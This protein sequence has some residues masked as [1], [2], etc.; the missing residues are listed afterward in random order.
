MVAAHGEGHGGG[1]DFDVADFH[2]AGRQRTLEAA[3]HGFDAGD[4]FARAEGLG[5]VV[6]GAEFETEDAVGFAAFGGQKN[7]GNGGEAG[8]LADGAAEFEAVF[9]GDHDVE[10]EERGAL[11][12]GVG[13]NVG[14]GGIDAHGEAFVFQMMADEAGN[15]GIV[16]DDEEAWFH[17]IIVNGK[18][19]R[20]C[21]VELP[22]CQADVTGANFI[23]L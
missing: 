17:G 14:A 9:A 10:H 20:G 12:F 8:S 11:A 6:V 4:E 5:D 13:E 21:R 16:F 1:I 7:Y 19:W 18:Q 2:G 15:V 22:D 23:G 3:Q